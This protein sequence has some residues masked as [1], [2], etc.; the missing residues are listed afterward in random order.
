MK[1]I[2]RMYVCGVSLLPI[3]LTIRH[4][5]R[6]IAG[7]CINRALGRITNLSILAQEGFAG[8]ADDSRSPGRAIQ[9]LLQGC[10]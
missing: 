10:G 5:V 7:V 6:S 1:N 8:G 2:I 9:K 3:L 4:N